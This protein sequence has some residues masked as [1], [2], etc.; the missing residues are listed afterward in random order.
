MYNDLTYKKWVTPNATRWYRR[1]SKTRESK[2]KYDALPYVFMREGNFFE[3]GM[4]EN[5]CRCYCLQKAKPF[6]VQSRF[7]NRASCIMHRV[8]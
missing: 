2:E 3:A 8:I 6:R 5:C 4:K 7:N 1:I